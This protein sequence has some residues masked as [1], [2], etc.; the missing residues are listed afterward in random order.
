M[1]FKEFL[2]LKKKGVTVLLSDILKMM[3]QFGKDTTRI[4]ENY[5]IHY[6]INNKNIYHIC[7]F[8]KSA[9]AS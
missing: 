7:V 4:L 6:S 3:T 1:Y 8:Y 5:G 2:Y 9:S